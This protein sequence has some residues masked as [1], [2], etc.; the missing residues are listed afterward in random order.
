M[1]TNLPNQPERAHPPYD[2]NKEAIPRSPSEVQ[3]ETPHT[4]PAQPDK[5]KNTAP[6][7]R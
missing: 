7:E 5:E 3:K 6:S 1:P 2:P 4:Y